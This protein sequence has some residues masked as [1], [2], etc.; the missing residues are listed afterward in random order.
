MGRSKKQSKTPPDTR[1]T[2]RL[3]A[4]GPN[5]TTYHQWRERLAAGES[6][7]V[8]VRYTRKSTEGDDRQATSHE[9]QAGA[10]DRKWGEIEGAWCWADSCSGTTFDRP[11]F[12]DLL[13]FCKSHRRSAR[14][15]GRVEMYD[16]SRFGRTLDEEGMPDIISFIG[17]MGEFERYGWVVEFVTVQR[18]G[19]R[20]VDFIMMALYAY[21]AALYSKSLSENV[22]RGRLKHA[23]EGWWVGGTAPWGTKRF[24]TEAKRELKG[25]E[26]SVTTGRTILVPDA[27]VLRLWK[28]AAKRI[29]AGASL[30]AVGAELFE[31]GVRGPRD[32]KM[33]HAAVRNFLTNVA[34]IGMMEYDEEKDEA[35]AR[36]RCRV[37]AKW[38]AMVDEDLFAKVA[39]RLH[40]HTR[41]RAPRRRRRRELFPLTPACAHCGVEYNG[42]RLSAAQGSTRGYAHAKPNQRMDPEGFA[43]REAQGCK[44][45]YVDAEELE[46]KIK[47]VIVAERTSDDFVEDVRKLVQE[48]DSF[49]ERADEA[50]ASAERA[51]AAA[52]E[53][54]RSLAR[55]IAQVAKAAGASAGA[56]EAV[57]DDATVELSEQLG[58]AKQRQRAAEAE[59]EKAKS[60]AQSKE[61]AW[62]RLEAIIHESRNLAAAWDKSG[63]EERRIL[64]DYW[65]V[66]VLIVVEPIPGMRRANRKTALVRLRSAPNAPR[67]FE[68]ETGQ[69]TTKASSSARTATSPSS[70][71]RAR[72]AAAAAGEPILPKAHAECART[73][74]SGSDSAAARTGTS[75]SEPTLPSTTAE[76]RRSPRSLARF[77]GEP[78]NAAENSGCDMAS[79]SSASERESFPAS[80]DRAAND[81]SESSRANL[82]LYGHTS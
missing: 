31:K 52:R 73:S 13:D 54:C 38:P 70:S 53:E 51:L 33:G 68:L 44:A 47:D 80:A 17:V 49:R 16:P 64:L 79:S 8:R 18:T 50:V 30:D 77:I 12:Q 43:R 48:R 29:L 57:D 25:R 28:R 32:G 39:E 63:P 1:R 26:R 37:K 65:V 82:W 4:A 19:D 3:G 45:W 11:A 35:G 24:D 58:A 21:A 71:K 76:L 59:L 69:G 2:H 66:D 40:G 6:V 62:E 74:G 10:M 5:G 36:K 56:G 60:F 27:V 78:L 14:T 55:S 20:L 46:S 75:S 15:P 41:E 61:R 67:H 23:K 81:G 22:T 7:P 42:N 9:Q 72:R 34:L